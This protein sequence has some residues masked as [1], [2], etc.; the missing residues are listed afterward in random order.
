M[1]NPYTFVGNSPWTH[2]DPHG[3][4]IETVWDAANVGLGLA[5][6]ASNGRTLRGGRPSQCG[7]SIGGVGT[8]PRAIDWLA[9][10]ALRSSIRSMMAWVVG[11]SAP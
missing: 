7:F 5:S 1:G 11:N 9:Y 8:V 4:A 6:F 3:E 2:T 10:F